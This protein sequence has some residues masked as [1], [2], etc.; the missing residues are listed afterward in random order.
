LSVSVWLPRAVVWA[1]LSWGIEFG[2]FWRRSVVFGE[3]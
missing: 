1:A 3:N 2:G